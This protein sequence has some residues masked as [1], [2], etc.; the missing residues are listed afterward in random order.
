MQHRDH[1]FLEQHAALQV[2][3]AI[4]AKYGHRATVSCSHWGVARCKLLRQLGKLCYGTNSPAPTLLN[5]RDLRTTAYG[6][7]VTVAG[8]LIIRQQPYTV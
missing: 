8:L 1:A 6:K 7:Y 2:V 5:S 3:D 4:R